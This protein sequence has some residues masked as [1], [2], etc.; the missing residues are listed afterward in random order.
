MYAGELAC[1]RWQ[2]VDGRNAMVRKK[3]PQGESESESEKEA[4][5]GGQ[6][7]CQRALASGRFRG[8][9][10]SGNAFA[11]WESSTCPVRDPHQYFLLKRLQ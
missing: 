7:A 2:T 8:R 1:Q 3:Q 4:E 6:G 9:F 10:H 5:K 11:E